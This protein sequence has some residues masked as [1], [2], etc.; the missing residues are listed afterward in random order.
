[1]LVSVD[2]TEHLVPALTVIA[3][4]YA[5]VSTP[6]LSPVVAII[7]ILFRKSTAKV[8]IF[9]LARGDVAWGTGSSTGLSCVTNRVF[10]IA[11]IIISIM[12]ALV[13]SWHTALVLGI[14]VAKGDIATSTGVGF[15]SADVP[16]FEVPIIR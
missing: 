4:V 9:R 12:S 14:P 1:M 8:S 5:E 16:T 7:F 11:I 3:P 13:S 15:M 6:V 10:S 2:D